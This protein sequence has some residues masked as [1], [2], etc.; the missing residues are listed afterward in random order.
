MDH[1][2]AKFRINLRP[3]FTVIDNFIQCED[4]LERLR[5]HALQED[6]ESA[7]AYYKGRRTFRTF[8][9]EELKLAF[10]RIL[11]GKISDWDHP[12]N[13][14]NGKLQFCTADT[15]LVYHRDSLNYAGILYLTPDAP[16][17]TGTTL[18]AHKE[19]KL[20]SVPDDRRAEVF[21][22][23]FFDKTKFEP[24]DVIGNVYNRLF[25]FDATNIH[26]ASCYFGKD[27]TDSRLFQ[28]FFFNFNHHF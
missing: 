21:S 14:M 27:V 8:R 16:F 22:G 28:I 12:A 20:R 24:V 26:A 23:G 4:A 18:Y 9:T 1:F 13:G 3:S 2:R 25:L 11:N 19:T 17:S 5:N 6:Y 10:E 15:P 7:S